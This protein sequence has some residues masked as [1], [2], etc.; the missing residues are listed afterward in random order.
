MLWSGVA[1]SQVGQLFI[2]HSGYR[3]VKSLMPMY[4]RRKGICDVIHGVIRDVMPKQL[5][6]NPV[7]ARPSRNH[8][9]A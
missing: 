8:S 9:I 5:K 1:K 7:D 6:K 4:L 3:W 2:S